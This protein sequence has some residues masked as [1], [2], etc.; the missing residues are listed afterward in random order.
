MKNLTSPIRSYREIFFGVKS[1]ENLYL[2][3]GINEFT[4]KTDRFGLFSASEAEPYK[5][6]SV[7]KDERRTHE[8]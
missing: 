2:E 4:D 1:T 6:L 7:K 5:F 3:L 8:S